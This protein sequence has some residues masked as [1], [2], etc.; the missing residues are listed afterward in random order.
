MDIV[1]ERFSYTTAGQ[2]E[3]AFEVVVTDD[4][5][6]SLTDLTPRLTP[7][8]RLFTRGDLAAL[9]RAWRD[10]VV[11]TGRGA[12]RTVVASGRVTSGHLN[13]DLTGLALTFTLPLV[14]GAPLPCDFYCGPSRGAAEPQATTSFDTYKTRTR[15]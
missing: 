6:R 7:V 3:L 8:A 15:A 9:R 1:L 4:D 14:R 2:G 5:A 13:I 10:I 12:L 11:T